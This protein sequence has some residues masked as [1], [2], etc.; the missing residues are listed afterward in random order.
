[1]LV[2]YILAMVITILAVVIAVMIGENGHWYMAWVL[3]TGF[4]ILVAASGAV[5]LEQQDR[6][7]QK[8]S[9]S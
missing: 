5:L 9:A 8:D 6:D 3:G 4:M 7:D 1:M 2:R